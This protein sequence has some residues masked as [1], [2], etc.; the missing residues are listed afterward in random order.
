MKNFIL[1]A[2][3]IIPAFLSAQNALPTEFTWTKENG[4][5]NFIV[6]S[7]PGKTKSELYSKASEW[8]RKKGL[9]IKNF[10]TFESFGSEGIEERLWC[11]KFMGSENCNPVKYLIDLEFKDDKIKFAVV[12]ID[13][14]IDPTKGWFPYELHDTTNYYNK[15]GEMKAVVKPLLDALPTYFNNLSNDLKT[16]ITTEAPKKSEW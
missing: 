4:L 6:I 15:K 10:E 12:F 1:V 7:V 14:K 9:A 3:L 13:V 5:T 2:L 11:K 8:E 16:F